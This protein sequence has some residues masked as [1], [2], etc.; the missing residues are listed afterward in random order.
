MCP[1]SDVPKKKISTS[2]PDFHF[3]FSIGDDDFETMGSLKDS[4][5]KTPQQV[6]HGLSIISSCGCV[7]VMKLNLTIFV[8]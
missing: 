1:V 7:F 2:Q 5:R 3:D 6:T 8:L 4:A